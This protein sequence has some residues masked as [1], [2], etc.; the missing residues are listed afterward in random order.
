MHHGQQAETTQMMHNG[1]NGGNGM[2]GSQC[3]QAIATHQHMMGMYTKTNAKLEELVKKM[4]AAKGEA[5]LAAMSAVIH[6]L[7]SERT[8]VLNMMGGQAN[9]MGQQSGMTGHMGGM[10]GGSMGTPMQGHSS[11][12]G[13]NSTNPKTTT[14]DKE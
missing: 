8:Q 5:K 13:T 1:Q 6:E 9:M 2:M 14:P 12:M 4:D 3:Q 11:M 7:L 10:H